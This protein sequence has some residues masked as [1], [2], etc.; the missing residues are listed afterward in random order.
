MGVVLFAHGSR[1]GRIWENT[2]VDD[3][4]N[5]QFDIMRKLDSYR[6]KLARINMMQCYSGYQGTFVIPL[7]H[8]AY[9]NRL[10]GE[11]NFD[12]WKIEKIE[13][14]FRKKYKEFDDSSDV[15]IQ[16]LK[17]ISKDGQETFRVGVQITINWEKAWFSYGE[18][19]TIY[20]N[21]NVLLLDMDLDGILEKWNIFK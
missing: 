18:K 21:V 10:S 2:N 8:L 9:V 20:R 7:K 14:F 11:S 5:W 13:E 1:D 6:Y 3:S 17:E 19:I 15:R 4:R 16:V 12:A